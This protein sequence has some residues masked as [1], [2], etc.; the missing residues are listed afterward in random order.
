MSITLEYPI[1]KRGS[2][3]NRKDEEL[4][5]L[6]PRGE[7]MDSYKGMDTVFKCFRESKLCTCSTVLHKRRKILVYNPILL[8]CR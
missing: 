4:H 7:S 1:S 3:T 8:S 2:N 6:L 5:H